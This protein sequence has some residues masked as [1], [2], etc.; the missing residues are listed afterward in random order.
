MRSSLLCCIVLA[1]CIVHCFAAGPNLLTNP[2]FEDATDANWPVGWAP[3][4]AERVGALGGALS[5]TVRH[6]GQAAL[7]VVRNE[8]AGWAFW[9]QQNIPI[10]PGLVYDL[11]G[12]LKLNSVRRFGYPSVCLIA[13]FYDSADNNIGQMQTQSL[14]GTADWHDW[15]VTVTAPADAVK[16]SVYVEFALAEGEMWADDVYFRLSD[17][18]P[19]AEQTP[20]LATRALW[21]TQNSIATPE[22]ANE[23][24]ERAVAAGINVLVPCAYNRGYASYRGGVL[25][26]PDTVPE[27]FDPLANIIELAHARGIEV[28]PWFC[29]C[30]GYFDAL[31]ADQI[32]PWMS[33]ITSGGKRNIDWADVHRPQ[34]RRW[35]SQI[36]IDVARRYDVDGIH[37]D[38]IRVGTD[39][40]CTKC[41]AEFQ[42]RFG[43]PL[44]DATN[45]E[46]IEWHT[47]AITDIVR[48][49]S[50]ALHT[51]NPHIILSAAVQGPVQGPRGGQ[52]SSRWVASGI[53]DLIMPMDYFGTASQLEAIQRARIAELEAVGSD[54]SHLC[55]GLSIYRQVRS[56]EGEIIALPRDPADVIPNVDVCSRLGISG[57]TIFADVYLE[58]EL[59]AALLV[60]FQGI[61]TGAP[62]FRSPDFASGHSF[63]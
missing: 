18:A 48:R 21:A 20:F 45:V 40:Y 31:P 47:A 60:Q 44:S 62:H 57:V 52:D 38:Y 12:F 63:P 43:H 24:I 32:R 7:H 61:P 53:L 26:V 37:Y 34:F 4:D 15:R 54:V 22:A 13:L 33:T 8:H 14:Y 10:Q 3:S 41:R 36:M 29:V 42:H 6:S 35:I 19:L 17:E 59:A 46:F 28:H 55:T 9:K 1:I 51:I 25:P 58:P 50:T 23:L 30:R 56:K 11:G 27:N 16:V 5:S 39:C 2:G 49:T